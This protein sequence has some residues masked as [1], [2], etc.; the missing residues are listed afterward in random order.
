MANKKK[1]VGYD[2]NKFLDTKCWCG[3]SK[4]KAKYEANQCFW[5]NKKHRPKRVTTNILFLFWSN[6]FAKLAVVTDNII[7]TNVA[8]IMRFIIVLTKVEKILPATKY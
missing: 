1:T 8:V 3:F 6:P 4:K 2:K 7:I 5:F